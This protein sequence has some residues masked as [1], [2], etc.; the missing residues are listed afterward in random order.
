M[1]REEAELKAE[2]LVKLAIQRKEINDK[3]RQLK[4]ELLEYTDIENIADVAWPADNG[5]VEVMTETKYKLA[6]VPAEVKVSSEV[7]AID[8]A[9]KAFKSKISLT[10]EG[11]ELFRDRHPSIVKLMIPTIKKRLKITI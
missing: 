6:D 4:G 8:I 5:L 10:R 2:E 11:K 9:E 1:E 7:A 3:I